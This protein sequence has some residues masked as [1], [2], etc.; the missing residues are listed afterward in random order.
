M[1]GDGERM[2]NHPDGLKALATAL[3]READALGRAGYRDQAARQLIEAR[4]HELRAAAL[5]ARA[6]LA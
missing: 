2:A 5:L 1:R 3:R 4:L 6:E